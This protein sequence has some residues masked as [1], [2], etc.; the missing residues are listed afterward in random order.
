MWLPS[1]LPTLQVNKIAFL[2]IKSDR[3]IDIGNWSRGWC[4]FRL[5]NLAPTPAEACLPP[6]CR[7][8]LFSCG[9]TGHKRK[10]AEVLSKGKPQELHWRLSKPRQED[11][12]TV[13]RAFLLASFS[14]KKKKQDRKKA[15]ILRVS[16]TSLESCGMKMLVGV[17]AEWGEQSGGG[18]NTLLPLMR[19]ELL[20]GWR[21]CS[22]LFLCASALLSS[23]RLLRTL[24]A[25][26]K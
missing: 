4:I 26:S 14:V 3:F 25:R 1:P 23:A 5:S 7:G 12:K 16:E 18:F 22:G 13:K 2:L 19:R 9:T 11:V 8:K 21:C 15:S 10:A 24:A 17:T 20:W 6:D